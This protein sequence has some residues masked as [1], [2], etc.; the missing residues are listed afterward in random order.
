[1]AGPL[2]FTCFFRPPAVVPPPCPRPPPP[3]PK[4]PATWLPPLLAPPPSRFCIR[5]ALSQYRNKS[6]SSVTVLVS[7]S[8]GGRRRL[9]LMYLCVSF[10]CTHA[11][12]YVDNTI[13]TN[14]KYEHAHKYITTC[15]SYAPTS[16]VR[17]CDILCSVLCNHVLLHIARGSN[18]VIPCCA[19]VCS[20]VSSQIPL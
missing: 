18:C 2:Y 19:M 8:R 3:P 13:Q 6:M 5:S 17:L 9:K 7:A 4:R 15:R 14:T 16:Y 10:I 12:M 11:D 1:M 20:T